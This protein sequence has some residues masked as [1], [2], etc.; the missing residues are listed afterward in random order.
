MEFSTSK[1]KKFSKFV[2]LLSNTK[3]FTSQILH[4]CSCKEA[5]W[6]KGTL[7][8]K[9]FIWGQ[10]NTG[11]TR[12]K[13]LNC[14]PQIKLC[15]PWTSWNSIHSIECACECVCQA[16]AEQIAWGEFIW[17]SRESVTTEIFRK[18][19]LDWYSQKG[20][21]HSFK[22]NLPFSPFSFLLTYSWFTICVNFSCTAKWFSYTYKYI[23][24]IFF[25]IMVYHRIL[26]SSLC[27]TVG[28]FACLFY[29]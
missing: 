3:A 6:I 16:C 24:I 29:I 14:H 28:P 4:K 7:V 22:K 10:K 25:S 11:S 1:E 19:P 23:F 26:Y 15:D 18:S 12:Q 8:L 20:R 27:C 9:S 13:F 2:S 5:G 17:V 21:L